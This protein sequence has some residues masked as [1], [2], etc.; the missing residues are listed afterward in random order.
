MTM[1]RKGAGPWLVALLAAITIFV[2]ASL[3]DSTFSFVVTYPGLLFTWPFWPEG[4]HTGSGGV[5]SAVGFYIVFALGNVVV[6]TLLL[7]ALLSV[8]GRLRHE[9]VVGGG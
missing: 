5:P 3:L 8:A 9:P 1:R 4:I 6:W 2:V 7:R